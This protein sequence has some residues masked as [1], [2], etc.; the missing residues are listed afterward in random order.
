ML[1]AKQRATAPAPAPAENAREV[2]LTFTRWA[3]DRKIE[4]RG[5][6]AEQRGDSRGLIATQP[7][8]RG[9][10][11]VSVPQAAVLSLRP[12]EIPAA[13]VANQVCNRQALQLG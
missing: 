9:D 13:G 1:A 5:A 7:L 10:T 12:D 8:S 3:I 11:L 2:L 4:F 6:R